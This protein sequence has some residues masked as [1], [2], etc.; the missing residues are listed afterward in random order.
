MRTY[1]AVQ[2]WA[3]VLAGQGGGGRGECFLGLRVEEGGSEGVGQGEL[4]GDA[5]SSC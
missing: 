1:A 5:Q 3:F 4:E 2:G